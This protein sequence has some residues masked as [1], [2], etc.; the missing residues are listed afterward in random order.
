MKTMKNEKGF[1]YVIMIACIPV[2]VGTLLSIFISK[3]TTVNAI[4]T[5]IEVITERVNNNKELVLSLLAETE[6]RRTEQYQYLCKETEEI[7]EQLKQKKNLTMAGNEMEISLDAFMLSTRGCH[8]SQWIDT[9]QKYLEVND[10]LYSAICMNLQTISDN[11][12]PT[13]Y[14]STTLNSQ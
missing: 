6:K 9:L 14:S 11:L 5:S 8:Q 1:W 7:K 2:V 3:S 12:P 13:M 10:S 4:A